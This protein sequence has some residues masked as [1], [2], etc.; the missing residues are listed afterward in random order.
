[1]GQGFRRKRGALA[2]RAAVLFNIAKIRSRLTPP[3]DHR[4][5]DEIDAIKAVIDDLQKDEL[6]P[7]NRVYRHALVDEKASLATLAKLERTFSGTPHAAAAPVAAAPSVPPQAAQ[8]PTYGSISG[9]GRFTPKFNPTPKLDPAFDDATLARMV[10]ERA[11]QSQVDRQLRHE[12]WAAPKRAMMDGTV[13][14]IMSGG[15]VST[16]EDLGKGLD[17]FFADQAKFNAE[18]SSYDDALR[19]ALSRGVTIRK[20]PDMPPA[21][22]A[23]IEDRLAVFAKRDADTPIGA[24]AARNLAA[25]RAEAAQQSQ[26]QS[27]STPAP[28]TGQPAPQPPAAEAPA[29]RPQP[30]PATPSASSPKPAEAKVTQVETAEHSP[31]EPQ[32]APA[33]P[34]RA[35][36]PPN[37]YGR[38]TRVLTPEERSALT[39]THFTSRPKPKDET[40]ETMPAHAKR[41][42]PSCTTNHRMTT[43]R[44]PPC[45]RLQRHCPQRHHPPRSARRN[46]TFRRPPP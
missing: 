33:P 32:P 22:L 19:L 26:Q 46:Q 38:R 45:R 41:R 11:R 30:A 18:M 21:E 8:R 27:S 40:P 17:A 37:V 29:V 39:K 2:E 43:H 16:I 31:V 5:K 9:A 36:Q 28:S 3:L 6:A 15:G 44:L 12:A 1:M 25:W 14:Q 24:A 20:T 34:Q 4:P 7:L 10:A 23:L 42:R 13:A 35:V